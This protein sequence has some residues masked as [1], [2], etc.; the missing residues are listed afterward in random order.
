MKT[1]EQAQ[2]AEEE[3]GNDVADV[4][5]QLL[6]YWRPIVGGIVLVVVGVTGYSVISGNREAALEQGWNRFLGAA[7]DR[8]PVE[9]QTLADTAGGS[10]GAWSQQA[11]AQAKLI[12]ASAAVHTNRDTAKTAFAEAVSGFKKAISSS[13]SHPLIQQRA[14]WGLAQAHEGLNDLATAKQTYQEIVDKWPDTSIAK[15]ASKR[16]AS[17]DDPATADFYEWFFAQTPPAAKLPASGEVPTV[18]FGVPDTPDF[19][20][21]DPSGSESDT[22]DAS[23]VEAAIANLNAGADSDTEGSAV[24]TTDADGVGAAEEVVADA[25]DADGTGAVDE[26]VTEAVEPAAE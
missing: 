5:E 22:S 17:L 18:P 24:E 2:I 11:A 7:A 21:P 23:D 14:T 6:P 4:L 12:E 8:N 19:S 26:I 15:Q 13:A 3:P 20:I 10:V 25:A 1:D 16:V 9:L